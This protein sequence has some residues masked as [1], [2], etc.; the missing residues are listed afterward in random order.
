MRLLDSVPCGENRICAS[1]Y[2]YWCNRRY[3]A[4]SAKALCLFMTS[5]VWLPDK[6]RKGPELR[7]QEGI[8]IV[9]IKQSASIR[10]FL[11]K[12][13]KIQLWTA[14]GF[15]TLKVRIQIRLW[16]EFLFL[17]FHAYTGCFVKSSPSHNFTISFSI[18]LHQKGRRFLKNK[19]L[20]KIYS[21]PWAWKS[22]KN[23]ENFFRWFSYDLLVTENCK[24]VLFLAQN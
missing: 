13:T 5:S 21:C 15:Q 16:I 9:N 17:S 1:L 11:K 19:L 6:E 14:T 22:S 12:R 20:K 18:F 4:V 2:R 23:F 24:I 7:K 8:V 10:Y 3:A